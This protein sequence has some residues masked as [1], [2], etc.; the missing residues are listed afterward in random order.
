MYTLYFLDTNESS[1]WKIGI[2]NRMGNEIFLRI[3]FAGFVHS[4]EKGMGK[5]HPLR[6]G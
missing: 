1:E 6:M 5:S 4:R 2:E 3:F